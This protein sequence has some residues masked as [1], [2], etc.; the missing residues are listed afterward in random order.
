M[1]HMRDDELAAVT[2]QW[3]VD[4][5]AAWPD[6]AVD[7]AAFIARTAARLPPEATP[8]QALALHAADLWL[9]AACA[10]GDAKALAHLEQAYLSTLD[11]LLASSGLAGDQIE[12]VKQ[13]LRRKL[14]VADAAPPRILEYSG[15]S[16]LRLWLRTTAVRLGI[17]LLRRRNAL[18]VDDD[19]LA[20]MPALA[21]D[22]EIAHL[23]Q[24][25]RDEL[26]EAVT[27]AIASLEPRDRLLLKYHY[28]DGLSIDR[29]GALYGIHRSSAAR[30]LGAARDALAERTHR[31]LGARVGVT[32]SQ[33]RSIARLVESQL[34]LS[35]RRL[36]T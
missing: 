29:I 21:D 18:P 10:T 16:D 14:L 1:L 22:P 3:L 32:A 4:A 31:L 2:A 20:A 17:D 5:H 28:V 13:E 8:E 15:R 23:K 36:L 35:I 9:A 12:D 34:D 24:R 25:Y 7:E 19:E 6:L 11:K 30:W 26:R 27:D 33:L